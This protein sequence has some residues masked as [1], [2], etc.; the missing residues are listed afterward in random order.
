MIYC[1]HI[2][3]DYGKVIYLGEREG[4]IEREGE[5]GL[6][7]FNSSLGSSKLYK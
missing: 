7:S 4:D 3:L 5:E 6:D 1:I 2:Y